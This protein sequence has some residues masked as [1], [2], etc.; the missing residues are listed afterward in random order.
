MEKLSHFTKFLCPEG[1]SGEWL[2]AK[3]LSP[4]AKVFPAPRNTK[5]TFKLFSHSICLNFLWAYGLQHIGLLCPS[6]SS[7]VCSNSC[8]SSR[9]CHPNIS[10]CHPPSPPALNLSQYQ[11]FPMSWFFA[12]HGQ[13]TRAS[14]SALVLL[15]NIQGWFSLGLTGLI[16]LLSKGLSRVFSNTTV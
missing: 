4:T 15:M 6:P 12:S 14:A 7:R 2:R 13:S 1:D 10:S 9:W 16:S 8:S 3:S 11:S 5:S